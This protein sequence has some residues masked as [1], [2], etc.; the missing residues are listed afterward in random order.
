MAAGEQIGGC[1]VR[2][3]V[4]LLLDDGIN[5][6]VNPAPCQPKFFLIFQILLDDLLT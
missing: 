5:V 3:R 1:D 6:I 4:H 2:L